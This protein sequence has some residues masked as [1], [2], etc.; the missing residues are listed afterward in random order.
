MASETQRTNRVREWRLQRGWSQGELATRAAISRTAVSA[1]EGNRVVPSVLAALALA[2]SFECTV[3]ELFGIHPAGGQ[4]E[5]AW[6]PVNDPCRFWEAEVAGRALQFPVEASPLGVIPHDGVLEDGRIRRGRDSDRAT[7]I[8]MASC[9]PAASLLANELARSTRFRLLVFPRSSQRAL[10]MLAAGVV[11]VAGIHLSTEDEPDCNARTAKAKLGERCVLIRA[12]RWQEGITF[13]S[14]TSISSLRAALASSISWV[15][16]EPGSG[17]RQ[18]LDELLQGRNRPR[19]MAQDHRGVAE[20]VRNG[21]ADAGVCHRL[22]SEEAGLRF[23]PVREE[24]FDLC[25]KA[26]SENDPRVQALLRV[27]RSSQYRRLLG[28][29]PGYDS[30]ETGEVQSNP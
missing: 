10:D 14:G 12:A 5:W 13:A 26:G 7:T 2:R 8:V 4:P 25:I 19:R 29:L 22:V 17:A 11:H 23:L 27:V 21:W 9:D 6:A 15:G 18:C 16:R 24:A 1:I 30:A 28:E 20:A 3:E